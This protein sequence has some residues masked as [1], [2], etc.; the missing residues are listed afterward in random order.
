MA[1]KT[2]DERFEE[3]FAARDKLDKEYFKAS[4]KLSDEYDALMK[5]LDEARAKK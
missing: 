2:I 1:K 4:D 5:E 3:H